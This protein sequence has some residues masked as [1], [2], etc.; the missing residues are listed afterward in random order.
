MTRQFLFPFA[1]L[2]V[3]PVTVAVLFSV[4]D[5]PQGASAPK[6]KVTVSEEQVDADAES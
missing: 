6:A 5:A 3:V 1:L 2:S 4:I